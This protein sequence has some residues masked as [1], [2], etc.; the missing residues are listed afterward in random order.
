M[1]TREL[2]KIYPNYFNLTSKAKRSLATSLGITVVGLRSWMRRKSK[3]E[4]DLE[5]TEQ[6]FQTLLK[7]GYG[8]NV[9]GTSK[10]YNLLAVV[11]LTQ[12]TLN[13]V[14]F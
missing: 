12:M 8:I 6:Q 7:Q 2:N 14:Y 5:R 9:S 3:E 1:Q 11:I 13:G 4:K 10:Y